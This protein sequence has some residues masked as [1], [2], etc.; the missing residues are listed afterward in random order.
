ML[1]P[2]YNG[3]VW[4]KEAIDSILA[5]TW[6]DFE[7]VIV[8]DGSTDRTPEILAAQHD[9]R[10]Q[11]HRLATNRGLVTALNH[12]LDHCA[13][14]WVARMDAD[15]VSEPDRLA[16]QLQVAGVSPFLGVIGSWMRE[17]RDSGESW[18]LELPAEHAAI[19]WR[20]LFR[21]PLYHATAIMRNEVVA[22][23]GGYDERWSHL[24]DIDL[25]ARL[26]GRTRFANV[27][28]AL[29]TRRL[30]D[31]SVCSAHAQVQNEKY[32]RV[33]HRL[34]HEWFRI[35]ETSAD[36]MTF[37][38]AVGS[39]AVLS[40]DEIDRATEMLVELSDSYISDQRMAPESAQWIRRDAARTIVQ[41][42]QRNGYV[43]PA[44]ARQW[45]R[46]ILPDS[47]K[48]RIKAVLCRKQS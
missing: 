48:R 17:R 19:C 22:A 10:I 47:V 26:A 44:V 14:E 30:H 15:D 35:P 41:V 43:H 8:D 1:L 40:G 13:G 34:L 29:Y 36:A 21:C 31:K 42:A 46:W 37:C 32:D 39:A 2:V 45:W 12:G 9:S 4:L 16:V 25:L 11:I 24:E 38:K 6:S 5:Q 20:L 7:F 28:D 33:R 23:A 18:I 27:P 3:E